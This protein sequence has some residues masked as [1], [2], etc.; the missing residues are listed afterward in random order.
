MR[1][2]LLALIV[3]ALP[4][5]TLLAVVAGLA[6]TQPDPRSSAQSTST[7]ASARSVDLAALDRA[8][9]PGTNF[10]QFACGGWMASNPVSAGTAR[11]RPGLDVIAALSDLVRANACRV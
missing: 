10:Y 5:A 6:T 4:A 11:L 2:H 8:T 1:R 7:T 9:A 3:V